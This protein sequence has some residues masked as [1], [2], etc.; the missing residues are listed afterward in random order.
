MNPQ[1]KCG[2]FLANT[3]PVVGYAE[4]GYASGPYVAGVTGDCTRCGPN[5]E[6]AFGPF[7]SWDA[8]KWPEGWE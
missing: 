7:H 2:R 6:A 8:W 5:V 1:C 3:R 4:A